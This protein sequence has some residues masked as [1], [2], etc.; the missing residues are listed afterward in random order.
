[1]RSVRVRG[2]LLFVSLVFVCATM[3]SA[4]VA[5]SASANQLTTRSLTLQGIGTVGGSTPGG[6]VN[7]SFQ[8]TLPSV[9][10]QS[11]GSIKFLYCT[12]ASD[13]TGSYAGNS[14]TAPTGLSVTGGTLGTQ[15]GAAGF[16]STFGGTFSNNDATSTSRVNGFYIT[17]TAA[18]VNAATVVTMVVNNITNPT[19]VSDGTNSGTFF[20]RISTYASTNAT[21]VP[22]DTGTVAA[23]TA[24]QIQLQGIMPESLIFCTGQ[25]VTTNCTAVTNGIISFDVLFGPT[26]TAKA[27]SQMAASTN[28]PGG[29]VITVNG[30]TLTSGS[31]TITAIGAS[32]TTPAVGTGQFGM[33]LKLNT[34]PAIGAEVAPAADGTNT[35]GQAKAG[36]N[37][38]N[39]YKFNTATSDIVAASDYTA[40]GATN[41]QVYTVSYIANV[42]GNQAPGTYITTLT[43]ICTPT[44]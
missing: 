40:A 34:T 35:R 9:G 19:T 7:H 26:V 31:N 39:S 27:T 33:N 36:F 20:V 18:V 22:I 21:G 24:N 30:P 25:T 23:S 38:V 1:M 14:C 6:V 15:T 17:R 37:T 4:Y 44:F 29:Y 41:S 10:N 11:V 13:T 8:F 16:S 2:R 3:A 5:P 42:P 28:A 32:A 43:Y 12:T